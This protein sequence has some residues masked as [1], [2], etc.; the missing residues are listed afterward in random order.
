MSLILYGVGDIGPCR[1]DVPSIF[2]HVEQ[3]FNEEGNITFGQLETVLSERGEPMIHARMTCSGPVS[4]APALKA[5]GFDV[6]SFGSNHTMDWGTTAMRDTV[7]NLEAAGLECIGVGRR[8]LT[9]ARKPA[10]I[11][12]NG[13]KV[14][15]LGY[16]S[17]LPQG[18][19]ADER[20]GGCNPARGLT[21]YEQIEHDQPGTPARVHSFPLQEDLDRMLEDIKAVRDQADI[22]VVSFHWGIHFKPAVIAQYQRMYAHAAIDA[23][24]DV[25]FGH[26]A[27][28]LKPIEVYKGKAIFYS[29]SNFAMEEMY[30]YKRDIEAYGMDPLKGKGFKE[31]KAISNDPNWDASVR[32]FPP[33]SYKS[34]IAK[35]Y[36]EDKKI[37]AVSYLPVIIPLDSSPVILKQGDADFNEVVEYMNKITEMENL[38]DIYTVDGD[39]VRLTL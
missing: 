5:S 25:I 17:I 29:L 27:H 16:C 24:A 31:M 39:E 22:V 7:D 28:I 11:E 14:A 33:D 4:V 6:I 37:V 32:M 23:G 8:N 2:R 1:E 26:H 30:M 13:V 9:E 38:P 36:V 10:I 21:V 20:R 15:Y 34:V 19:W 3:L 35:C 18:Y 12:R